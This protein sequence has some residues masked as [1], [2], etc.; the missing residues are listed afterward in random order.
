M[1]TVTE[2]W[3]TI[4]PYVY[5]RVVNQC[6]LLYNTL[7]GATIESD[8]TE[9][10]ELLRETLQKENCGVVLLTNERDK[11][12]DINNFIRELREKY[13]GDIINVTLSNGK[14]VQMLPYFN[15]FS[16]SQELYK[17]HNFTPLKN[18]LENLSE[19]S[20]HID[21]KTEIHQL[22][23]FLQSLPERLTFNL[24]GNIVDIANYKDF[25]YYLDQHP[26]PKNMV[27]SYQNVISLQPDFENNFSYRIL[28]RFPIDLQQWNR[29]RE[30]LLNQT[31]PVEYIFDVLSEEDCRQ[32]EQ[33]VEQFRIEKYELHP[34]YTCDNIGFFEKNVFLTKEDLLSSVLSIKD[35]F[36]HQAM[37]I[38]NV[39]N[40][41]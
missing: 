15:Y 7:D 9:V 32:V 37:N 39:R 28:V 18:I 17:R 26:A 8:S 34:V 16:D 22:I 19:V 4:E 20:V 24:I 12:K 33:F 1:K 40:Y 29:S 41:P 14:P 2:Y 25:L 6:T 38:L 11:Q 35:I 21:D 3:F 23:Q 30:I 5:I 10:I 36:S 27:C 31:L 13:M